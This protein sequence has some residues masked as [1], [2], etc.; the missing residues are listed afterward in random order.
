V[1]GSRW[2][3]D[4]AVIAVSTELPIVD[5]L[6][7]PRPHR[8]LLRP[9]ELMT[10]RAGEAHRLPRYFYVVES[11]AKALNTRLTPNFGLWEFIEVDVHEAAALR[12]YPRYVPCAV[13]ILAVALELFRQAVGA[14]VRI[15]ANGGYRSPSHRGSTTGSPHCWAT[16][17]NIYR[18]GAEYVD[19]EERIRRYSEL[20]SKA[21]AGCWT[22]P[23]GSDRGEADD[24]LHL[25][26]GYVT[27][28]PR[29]QS[30][31]SGVS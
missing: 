11:S 19:T 31:A 21:M 23:Y 22:R 20:A 28:V 14:P 25:D 9:G 6:D 5:G 7:L 2:R 29:G 13:T 1:C 3:K 10:T 30:E 15:A 12:V 24:H 27:R 17:A 26:L 8:Q 18:V 16:A 4:V